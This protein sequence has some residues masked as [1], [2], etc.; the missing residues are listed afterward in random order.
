M[1]KRRFGSMHNQSGVDVDLAMTFFCCFEGYSY[2]EE[3]GQRI[4]RKGFD[5]DSY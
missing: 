1:A 2:G 4:L 3:D 5:F